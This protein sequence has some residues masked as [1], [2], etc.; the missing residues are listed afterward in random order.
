MR[1][2]LF[3]RLLN[4]ARRDDHCQRHQRQ[5]HQKHQSPAH[6]GREKPAH[7][8]ADRLR[9]TRYAYQCP[10]RNRTLFRVVND[11]DNRHAGGEHERS[12]GTL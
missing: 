7:Q 3:V 1:S 9:H 5:I 2:A 8:R 6:L 4:C 11:R 10:E 12:T